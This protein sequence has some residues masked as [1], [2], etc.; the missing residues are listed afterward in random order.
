M[1]ACR[2]FTLIELLVVIAIIALLIAILLP[3]LGSARKAGQRTRE[4]AAGQQLMI[5]YT[6]YSD[7]NKGRLLPGYLSDTLLEDWGPVTDLS[8]REL[9]GISVRRYPWR[10]AGYLGTSID[11]FYN[12]P[13]L[14][15]LVSANDPYAVSVFPSFGVNGFFAG[16]GNSGGIDPFAP[17]TKRVFGTVPVTRLHQVRHPSTLMSFATARGAD[18]TGAFPF[19][20]DVI[21]GYFEVLPPVQFEVTGRMW[22]ETYEPNS[23]APGTNSGFVSLRHA[24]A[25]ITTR[26]DGHAEAADF[27][28]LNDMRIW[29][30]DAPRADWAG[31]PT[32]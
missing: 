30:N 15:E 17:S 4:L 9:D 31:V 24:G 28:A 14:R 5:A 12:D 10:L 6:L 8:G 11:A 25:A 32:R 20:Q 21:E 7:D 27:G 23:S 18:T 3:A 29:S 2:G 13:R 16:G 19:G 26:M 22:G 1:A